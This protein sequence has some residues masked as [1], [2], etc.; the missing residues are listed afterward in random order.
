MPTRPPSREAAPAETITG[1][2]LGYNGYTDP[3]QTKPQMWSPG[4]M[5]VF[6]G[7]F[8]YI[9]RSR[10]ANVYT[11]S[12]TTGFPYTSLKYF[13]LPATGAW[14]MGDQNGKLYSYDTNNSYAQTQRIS[15]YWDPTGVGSSLLNGP[16]SRES[17]QNILYEMNG[18]VKQAG[19]NANAATIEGWGLDAP[20]STP[21]VAINAGISSALT[22][23]SRSNGVVTATAA[24][25]PQ[26]A[27]TY[28]FNIT[29]VSDPSFNGS[30][31]VTVSGAFTFTWSQPGQ[32]TTVGAG[33]GSIND[34]ITKAVGR[35]YVIAWE[36][37]NKSHI[38][39][40]SPATQYILYTSQYGILQLV[41]PGSAQFV[42]TGTTVTGSNNSQFTS[43]WV[44]RHLWMNGFGD[45][46]R[47]ISVQSATQLTVDTSHTSTAAVAFQVFDP[48]ATHLR[49]YA[50][51]DGGATYFRIARNAWSSSQTNLLLS[52]LQ[53]TDFSNAEPPSFPFT[54]EVAQVNNVPPPI[55]SFVNEY[56]GVLVVYGV[57]GAQQSFFYSNQTATTVGL[58]QESFAPLNQVT[59][60][61][62]SA[63]INGMLEFPGALIIWSNLQDMFRLTGLLT[64]N[65]VTG[66]ASGTA[67][68]QQGASV[69][70]LPYML[71]CANPFAADITPL[72]GFWLSSNAEIWLYTDTYAPR[73]IGRSVQDILNS[74]SPS[75]LSVAR[76]RYF[77]ANN[78][79]WIVF[80][81]AANGASY[82]NTLLILDIDL[83]ASNGSPSYFT[84]DMATN[85]P[86]WFVYQPG[87]VVNGAWTNRCDSL[88][89]VYEQTGRVRML[90][91]QVDLIQ[92]IDYNGGTGTEI[93]VPNG[94]LALHAY[95]NDSAT[96]L[97][98]PTWIRFN[99][100]RDPS[101]LSSEVMIPITAISR[102]NGLVTVTTAT[103]HNLSS[104]G[105]VDNVFI[106][107][108][109]DTTYNG[110][111]PIYST[112]SN[113]TF[114]YIQAGANTSS[115]GG[116]VSAGWNFEIQGID[117]DY[118]TFQGPL[119][120]YL[121]PGYNDS[122]ALCG[123]P[124][125]L[126]GEA[127]RHSPE[128]FRIGGV[129]FC[130]GRRL[131][132]LVNFPTG[133]GQLYQLRAVQLGFGVNPPG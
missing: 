123:N 31:S 23:I 1:L 64:D 119:Q 72:G 59:L 108:V 18:Q 117:D 99:T 29:G 96:S 17:L 67:A 3:T 130:M 127:F 92:D 89:T 78:R 63:Q 77:H 5:N 97:K 10:F 60:P 6:A 71:G 68:A 114:T 93:G 40:P 90:T 95:G 65:T 56:Q 54:T 121:I 2:S 133:T 34:E 115:S 27:G 112:P 50:T 110:L 43:A 131:K 88:E 79:N 24:S 57:S 16:W 52:A 86:S 62:A 48:Q 38:G 49:L 14:L 102:T 113:T 118:Y 76:C 55:G 120:L 44:G 100:N 28:I 46:G 47:I 82:N 13:A 70:R 22:A 107:D 45:V 39:A 73:N 81:V 35:S 94:V 103:Q 105:F 91:G 9:Q 75:A 74:I 11:Q 37:A 85:S 128:L 12:P 61:V 42:A 69:A 132:F 41:E 58:L 84:F 36:N 33:F 109:T 125:L 87:T 15:G 20:D 124:D 51:A 25:S 101:V 7:A 32:N 98:R 19:R 116:L 4:T 80:A 111:Y 129:N 83:L 106:E 66:V 53:F 122:S 30:F 26:G 21:Q 126:G 8:G 104:T